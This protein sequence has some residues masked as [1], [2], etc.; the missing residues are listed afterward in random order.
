MDANKDQ[1]LTKMV[2]GRVF[3]IHQ[4]N[5]CN[6]FISLKNISQG[7]IENNFEF[8]ESFLF[9]SMYIPYASLDKMDMAYSFYLSIRLDLDD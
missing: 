9:F 7:R 5:V 2:L 3:P 6:A 8:Y 1:S 4:T